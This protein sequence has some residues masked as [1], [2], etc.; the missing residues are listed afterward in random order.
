MSIKTLDKKV[1]FS[2]PPRRSKPVEVSNAQPVDLA[3]P[4]R[5]EPS[6]N[7]LKQALGGMA[8]LAATL[9]PHAASAAETLV[10]EPLELQE[11]IIT[12]QDSQY[13]NYSELEQELAT[14]LAA[15]SEDTTQGEE[16]KP[17]F[18]DRVS[19]RAKGVKG[20][21]QGIK[22]KV[23]PD[24]W[25][26]SH[27]KDLGNGWH[28]SYE[29]VDVDLKPKWKDGG[30]ALRLKGEFL[31][32]SIQKKEDI[33]GGWTTT[34][35]IR[36]ELEG[37]VNT[38]DKP[39][40]DLRISAFKRW[41]GP[42]SEDYDAMFDVSVGVRDQFMGKH[43]Y[44]DGIS[45]GISMRQEIEG[46]GFEF[47]GKDYTWYL[48]GREHVYHNLDSGRTDANYKIMVGPKR[49][50]DVSLFGKKGKLS[51]TVGPEIKGS[52]AEHRDAFELGVGS[53]VR[54]RF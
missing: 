51:V 12:A 32:T 20:R 19:D 27:E 44:N 18:I 15:K 35:G 8:M 22:E 49:D 14:D 28:L 16:E 50:F 53:K 48:E 54:V 31:E 7:H 3:G 21:Y 9:A 46:G 5:T 33:G 52:T 30:P 38:Y 34:K 17:G 29:P 2:A 42:L 43:D 26:T 4:A 39:E 6:D 11:E 40:L 24:R 45:A 25:L 41:E 10:E 1:M 13:A 23:V 36:G 47:R 37:E